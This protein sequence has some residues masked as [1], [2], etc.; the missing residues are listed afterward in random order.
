MK[1]SI[2]LLA[3][4]LCIIITATTLVS[5]KTQPVPVPTETDEVTETKE[6]IAP[7]TEEV[8]EPE[9]EAPYRWLLKPSIT[10]DIQPIYSVMSSDICSFG[11]FLWDDGSSSKLIDS[12]GEF[13]GDINYNG[14]EQT[15]GY[16]YC[17]ACGGITDHMYLLNPDT[18]APEEYAGGHGG[19]DNSPLIYDVETEE[20]YTAY[21]GGY[22]LTEQIPD[23]AVVSL[24]KKVP[25]D[26][27]EMIWSEIDYKYENTEGYGIL[28]KGELKLRG[29]EMYSRYSNNVTAMRLDGKWGYYDAEGNE[30]L[31]CEYSPSTQQLYNALYECEYVPYQAT[32]GVIALCRDGKWGYADTK[33]RML[34]DF[35]FDEARPVYKNKGWVKTAEGWGIIEFDYIYPE[36][37][38]KEI[39]DS[40]A[41]RFSHDSISVSCEQTGTTSLYETEFKVYL[42]DGEATYYVTDDGHMIFV[43]NS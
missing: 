22:G 29:Y 43:H 8:Q 37:S 28:V 12:N 5:C 38:D 16:G 21:I 10:G 35:V 36:V 34:T 11:L 23:A 41:A 32:Y 9:P 4:L 19:P 17:D 6:P 25:L 2:R 39:A 42:I 15:Y 14:P 1:K 33:G 7:E 18:Y 24:C 3:I 40:F 20:I 13:K 31:S 27:N 26:E 30:I